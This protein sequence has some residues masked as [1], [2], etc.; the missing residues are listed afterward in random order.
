MAFLEIKNVRIAGIAAGVPKLCID[1][2]HSESQISTEYDNKQFVENTG[3]SERRVD[4]N[5]TTSDLCYPAAKRLIEELNWDVKE[6]EAVIFVSQYFDYIAP[7]TACIIQDKLGCSKECMAYDIEL[8]CSGWVYGLASISS[9]MQGGTIKKALL[10]AGDGRANYEGAEKY[11]G[12][13]FGQAGTVTALEYKEEVEPIRFHL[14]SDGGGFKALWVPGGGA[15][16]PFN[17]TSLI[18][19]EENGEKVTDITSRMNGMDVFSFGISTAPKSI[20]RLAEKFDFDYLDQDYFVFH[21]AN[22]KMNQMI[23]KK[24]KL[25]QDKLPYSLTHFG[26]TSSA[27]IPLTMVTQ[28]RDPLQ[29]GKCKMLCCGFGIGLSWGTVVLSTD[30]IKVAKLVEVESDEHML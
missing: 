7:A 9:L 14:G 3:V 25:P 17:S 1:N 11:S 28:L 27:S 19:K 10:M 21:Q 24:L 22:L 13:L 18:E 29:G 2:L 15:R 20:K 4:N 26:N 30:K 12:A 8:G 23:A 5:L 6:I 16:N